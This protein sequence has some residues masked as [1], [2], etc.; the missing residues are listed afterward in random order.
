MPE[1]NMEW[2]EEME[3][4]RLERPLLKHKKQYEEMMDEWES[5]GGRINPGALRRYSNKQKKNVTYEEWLEWIEEDREMCQALY[6]LV[7][8]N[9]ILGAISVRYKC[10][11]VDGHVGAG[12]RPSERRKGYATKML[13]LAFPFLKEFGHN[14]V[15]V[16]CDRGNIA[17]E[18]MILKNGG[19][20]IEEVVEEDGNIVKVFH[21]FY[22]L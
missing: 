5:F 15:V 12:I 7:N 10:A 21:I 14:P 16:S 8:D 19:K 9:N 17:S 22:K 18:K 11:G 20:F 2:N 6:F 1:V 3:N 13:S 4:L